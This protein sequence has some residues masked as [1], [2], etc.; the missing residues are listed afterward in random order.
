L[1]DFDL[2]SDTYDKTWYTQEAHPVKEGN[3]QDLGDPKLA[4]IM[5]PLNPVIEES[6]EDRSPPGPPSKT[7]KTGPKQKPMDIDIT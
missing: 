1:S 7:N 2:K 6:N 3:K 5:M 4:F